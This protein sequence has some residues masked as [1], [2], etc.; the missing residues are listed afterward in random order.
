V[1]GKK[2]MTR[3]ERGYIRIEIVKKEEQ[4]KETMKKEK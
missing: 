1:E 3:K 4:E 2:R